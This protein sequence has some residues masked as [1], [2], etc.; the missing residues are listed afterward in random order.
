MPLAGILE[1]LG[2]CHRLA[3]LSHRLCRHGLR[4]LVHLL[5]FHYQFVGRE[6]HKPLPS[7]VRHHEASGYWTEPRVAVALAPAAAVVVAGFAA[8]FAAAAAEVDYSVQR[9]WLVWLELQQVL[10]S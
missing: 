4:G 5:G 2:S 3:H 1:L 9:A 10:R 6:G 8:G 7:H